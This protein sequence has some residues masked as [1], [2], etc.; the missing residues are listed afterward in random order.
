MVQPKYRWL[1]L[2]GS[3]DVVSGTVNIDEPSI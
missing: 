1:Q 2:Q 3:E